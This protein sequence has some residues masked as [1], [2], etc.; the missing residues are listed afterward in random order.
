MIRLALMVTVTGSEKRA[1]HWTAARLKAARAWGLEESTLPGLMTM[2]NANAGV[3]VR[4]EA[5]AAHQKGRGDL[6]GGSMG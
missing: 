3:A 2:S 5:M 6:P 4:A 1:S